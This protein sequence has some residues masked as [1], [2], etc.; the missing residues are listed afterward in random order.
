MSISTPLKKLIRWPQKAA[1]ALAKIK[2]AIKED[3]SEKA[4]DTKESVLRVRRKAT[5]LF[6]RPLNDISHIG[7]MIV[8][9]VALLSGISAMFGTSGQVAVNPFIPAKATAQQ[10]V[11]SGE[12]RIAQADSVTTVAYY[13]DRTKLGPDAAAI[14]EQLNTQVSTNYGGT[15]YL[16]SL[17][18]VQN[19]TSSASKNK[20]T[21]YVVENGDTLST[22]AVKFNVSTDTIRY[23]NSIADINSIAPGDKLVI[24]PVTG[25]LHTVAAGETTASI[26][27]RY[28]AS[29]A[30]IIEQNSLYGEE[31]TVGMKLMVPDGEIPEAPKPVVQTKVASSG[32]G[33]QGSSQRIAATGKFL[34]PTLNTQGYYNGYHNWAID[35]PGSIG[36]PIFAADGGRIV[37]A[38][39]GW[40]GGY[41][42]TIL[43]DH[44][45]GYS[46]RYGHMSSLAVVGGYV[47]RGQVI[48][49]MGSTGR[50][51][52][53][54]L[55]FEIL[56][57]G[58]RQNPIYYF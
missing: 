37:E 13:I 39:Y 20:I 56:I 34:F 24:P 55:H 42:N 44:G 22:I 57:N 12:K 47:S 5:A 7:I 45:N 1:S 30:M 25:V 27:R 36:T 41:G 21:D 8:I 3:I 28:A 6:R 23:A 46:T 26:A 43:I 4:L 33:S 29:E 49:Y 18:I 40:N 58:V 9:A 15:E 19:S 51:T 48:G 16:A 53:S 11:S 14:T 17:P 32:G 31:L 35:I 38:Q 52:G 10:Y 2:P 54:H 50:S